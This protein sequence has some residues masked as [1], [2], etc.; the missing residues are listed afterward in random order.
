MIH[1]FYKY[2]GVKLRVIGN[3]FDVGET[4]LKMGMDNELKKQWDE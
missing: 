3:L 2:N 4:V 1:W